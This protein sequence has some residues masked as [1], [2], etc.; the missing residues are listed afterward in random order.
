MADPPPTHSEQGTAA[1][2]SDTTTKHPSLSPVS[3]GSITDQDSSSTHRIPQPPAQ[4]RTRPRTQRL[5]SNESNTSATEEDALLQ[6]AHNEASKRRRR[7][8]RQ[9][10]ERQL[11]R[12]EQSFIGDPEVIEPDDDD[13]VPEIARPGGSELARRDAGG[14]GGS[15]GAHNSGLRVRLD[16]NLEIEIMLKA[17]IHGDV[18]LTLF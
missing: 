7:R 16:M 17:K 8:H 9:Q 3:S 2:P 4:R 13:Q 5:L 14:V 12:R 10:R 11:I 1:A 6:R 15:G 18:T